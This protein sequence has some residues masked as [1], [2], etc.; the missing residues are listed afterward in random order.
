MRDRRALGARLPVTPAATGVAWRLAWRVGIALCWLLLALPAAAALQGLPLIRHYGT[1]ELPAAPSY[2]DLAVDAQGTLYAGSSEGV[3]VLRSGVWEL[4]ELPRRAA[5]FSL[6]AAAQGG[7]YVSGAGALGLLQ[8]RADGSLGYDD[9]LPRLAGND[10]ALASAQFYGLEQAGRG[11]YV[12]GGNTLFHVRRDGSIGRQTLP[13]GTAQ[14]AFAVADQLYIRIEGAGL[15]RVGP[16]APVLL[17][18]SQVFA[19]LRVAGIWA[20][21]GGLLVATDEGF[22]RSDANGTARLASDADAAFARHS[23]YVGIGLPDGGFVFA[24]YDGTLMHYRADLSLVDSFMPGA[25]GLGG[26]GFALDREGG[27][28]MAGESGITRLRLPSPWTVFDQRHGL[29]SRLYDSTWHNGQLWVAGQGLWRAQAA[30]RGGLPRFVQQPGLD[31][32]MEVFAV[33][34]TPAGLLIGDRLGLAVFDDGQSSPP[35]RL[36]GPQMHQGIHTLL[37]SA[38]AQ[39]RVLA[40]GTHQALWLAVQ[41][42][43]WQVLGRWE[44]EQGQVDGMY[45]MA[46]GEFWLGD[47]QGGVHR[48]RID[49]ATGQLQERRAFGAGDGVPMASGQGTHLVRIGQVLYAISGT[50]VHQLENERFVPALLPELPGLERPW[51]LAAA[52]TALGSFVWTTR[53]LWWRPDGAP[54]YQVLRAV[55][56]KVPGYAGLKLQA[57][58]RLRLLAR[59]RVLQ[60]DPAVVMR[61]A[62]SMQARVDRLQVIGRDG[63]LAALPLQ[64]DQVR[65]L[66]PGSGVAA[67]FGLDTLEPDIEFRYRM[68]GHEAAWS[69]WSAERE[70]SYRRLPPGDYTLE[71]QARIRGGARAVPLVYPLQVQPFWYERRT[72]QALF[73]LAAGLLVAVAMRLRTRAVLARNRDLERR[74][75]ARTQELQAAN[76]RLTELAVIDSLTGI[77]NR[78][79]LERALE[80]GWQRCQ[81]SGEPLAVVMADVDHFKLFNDTHGHQAGDVQLQRVA[82]QFA[83]EMLEVDELAARYGGEEFVLILPGLSLQQAMARA[84]RVRQGVEQALQAAGMP[85]SISLGVAAL[86][87]DAH[88]SPAD[89]MRR[90]DQALYQAKHAGRNCVEA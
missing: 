29:A 51:E 66:P 6:L 2:S 24:A 48:W 45:Q 23:P 22:Y 40:L 56:G 74:I 26:Y 89:V 58:G 87:P 82:A 83:D 57:D 77:A 79:A 76:A 30:A 33:H 41:A 84:E 20:W 80:R 43:R 4:F 73:L 63:A 9:L 90:A 27:L 62:P 35:R 17:P 15:A 34:G 18:G 86:V 38:A 59:D 65:I 64:A 37:P 31:P 78:H 88:N 21:R 49:T 12:R 8:T 5:V 28:W 69:S 3:M 36:L 53:Q 10:A 44:V 32:Q 13:P 71:L 85:G 39:D 7:V 11:V 70:I 46:A 1:D 55:N 47:G 68:A 72:V 60:L 54:A 61:N 50:L 75:T 16:D 19:G 42:G 67:R 14:K 81:R 52:Q 25:G